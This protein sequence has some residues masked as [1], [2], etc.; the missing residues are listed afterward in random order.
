MTTRSS[1]PLKPARKGTPL[2][3]TSA[4]PYAN[5]SI[6]VGHLVEYIQTDIFVRFLRST[7]EPVVYCCADD[8]HGAP[9][10][11]KA[12]ELK[13]T[14]EELIARMGEEHQRDFQAFHIQFD[15]YYTTHSPENK[16]FSDLIFTRLKERGY[17]YT[18]DV[19]VTFC[20][21]CQRN[22]PDR[23][24]K[25]TCPKCKAPDQYGDV[26]EHCHAT[27]TTVDLLEPYCVI[28]K[29]K[30]TRKISSHYFFKLSAFSQ[31][32][33][34]WLTTNKRLQPE[35]I[36]YVQNWIHEGLQDW[37]CSRDG[38]YFGFLIPG[39]KDKYYYVWLDAPIGYIAS[40]AHARHKK[41]QEAEQGWNNSRIIHF[42]GKDI[43]YFHFLFWPAML[44][45]A[46]FQL[47]EQIIVHGFLMVND[48]KMSKSRGT[49]FTAR[50][51]LERYPAEYLRFYYARV[52]SKKMADINLDFA[53][54]E[55]SINTELVA[56]IAN[57]CYRVLHF[58]QH[59]LG[60]NIGTVHFSEELAT[61][62]EDNLKKITESYAEVNLNDTLKGI[63]H[64]SALGN[65]YFQ[66]QEPWKQMKTDK[67]KTQEVITNAVNLV[68]DLSIL[69]QP[70]L[71]VFSQE[72]QKQLRCGVLTWQDLATK[73][74]HHQIGEVKVLIQKIQPSSTS[75]SQSSSPTS[76][77][78][79]SQDPFANLDL[80]VAT[81]LKVDDH[82]KADK[83]YV[84]Q[85]NLGSEKRQLVAGIKTAYTKEELLGKN[86]VVIANLKPAMLRG[87]ESQG[88]LLAGEDNE[89]NLGIV[90]V[91]HTTPGTSIFVEGISQKP[92]TEVT[93]DLFTKVA[94]TVKNATVH[95]NGKPLKAGTEICHV[96]HV[97]DGA[98]IR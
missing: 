42:I 82:P 21:Y 89:G 23:Y 13:I 64:F 78:P 35:I 5:G 44:M 58:C 83:L 2:I 28:C 45:G 30:P 7:G 68:K 86:I 70:I 1:R 51:F 26:C 38:P 25:G 43:I 62:R 55:Q 36:H 59:S 46:G 87:V 22:L 74:E 79:A 39:E 48:Q 76:Q 8:T 54:V 16:Y 19:E 3:V 18:K 57:F 65:K 29:Q 73:L 27:Y 67:E 32:L 88:M 71:P 95:Y 52:L 60:G 20:P 4:L 10:A 81:I 37:D 92:A 96:E 80:R 90:T 49:F 15:S 6:H 61:K 66:E 75:S 17:I 53:D 40:Y 63:L 34:D 50:E 14:P 69:V 93:L 94:L 11:I 84:L 56:N 91:S 85:I 41:T 24:V 77:P 9:I 31:Q 33:N 72:L 97:K 12:D 47:P 98:R